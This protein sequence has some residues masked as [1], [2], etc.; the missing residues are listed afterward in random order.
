[1][2]NRMCVILLGAILA[3]SGCS[4][5][6]ES[7]S[8]RKTPVYLAD[9]EIVDSK[10]GFGSVSIG[11]YADDWHQYGD[12]VSKG[13]PIASHGIAFPKGIHAHAPSHVVFSLGGKYKTLKVSLAMNDKIKGGDG[14]TV[15]VELDGKEILNRHIVSTSPP[16]RV[17]LDVTGGDILSLKSTGGPA[18]HLG[19]D[20]TIW[21][22]PVLLQ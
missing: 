15:I 18:G 3:T 20:W 12:D 5:L 10:A 8:L 19:C 21:G 6:Q 7:S 22:D 11:H 9:L 14:V 17:T 1:M 4:H 16:A 13:D 2:K